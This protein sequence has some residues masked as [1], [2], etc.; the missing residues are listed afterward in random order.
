L[1]FLKIKRANTNCFP[2]VLS[3]TA[4]D[5]ISK[6]LVLSP[7]GRLGAG[8]HDLAPLKSHAFFQGLNFA[9]LFDEAPQRVP[10]L[11][12]L[13]LRAVGEATVAARARDK[14]LL[15]LLPADRRAV[16]HFLARVERLH[17]PRVLRSFY[18]SLADARCLRALTGTR[19]YLGLEYDAQ[20]KWKEPFA[21]AHF[22]FGKLHDR[23]ASGEAAAGE[24]LGV[25][26][27]R[28]VS[29][30]N[31]LRPK[32]L[33]VTGD[34]STGTPASVVVDFRSAISRVS[35]SIPLVFVTAPSPGCAPAMAGFFGADWYGFWFG[36]MRGL[37]LNSA[38]ILDE[39]TSLSKAQEEWFDGECEQGQLGGHHLVVFTYHRWFER[40]PNEE[41]AETTIPKAP[42]LRWLRKLQ[43]GKVRHLFAGGATSATKLVRPG[44]LPKL[45]LAEDA[46]EDEEDEEADAAA[47][48]VVEAS[49]TGASSGLRVAEVF[50]DRIDHK[51]HHIDAIPDRADLFRST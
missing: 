22:C 46:G 39:E 44:D 25:H 7:E 6:L 29:A 12:E 49:C 31:R 21:F 18:G 24:A 3:E 2:E 37:V 9:T 41:D 35:E 40:N 10:K 47:A 15:A 36:G 19:E 1:T 26:L 23:N 11:S 48:R 14:R 50:E 5:L 8:S 45:E 20:G 16:M 38:L 32:L 42:R 4:V 34:F 27:K 51:C 28:L 43:Q 17:E 30:V 13:C 33:V